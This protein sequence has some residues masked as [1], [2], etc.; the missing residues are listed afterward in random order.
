MRGR[1][2]A[3][4]LFEEGCFA[5]VVEAQDE[6]GVLWLV[7]DGRVV[8]GG[9]SRGR[10]LPSL[11]VAWRYIDLKRWYIVCAAR[12]DDASSHVRGGWR[13]HV[14]GAL[15]MPS[16]PFRPHP[17]RPKN[18]LQISSSNHQRWSRHRSSL[19]TCSPS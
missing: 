10:V 8:F 2:G 6:D 4:Y 3:F 12:S 14:Y 19:L 11:L 7:L 16:T 9:L 5:G 18:S 15:L 17:F 1:V 13:R